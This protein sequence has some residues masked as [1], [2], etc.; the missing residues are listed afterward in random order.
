[1]KRLK[2][3]NPAN[4]TSVLERGEEA[5][6]NEDAYN[7]RI[8]LLVEAALKRHG[9][10]FVAIPTGVDLPKPILNRLDELYGDAARS[11]GQTVA[12]Y[13]SGLPLDEIR[14]VLRREYQSYFRDRTRKVP[15]KEVNF[16]YV[17]PR[18]PNPIFYSP[19]CPGSICTV[20]NVFSA[21]PNPFPAGDKFELVSSL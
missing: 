16:N 10:P 11:S 20:D 8:Q 17:P 15:F 21:P 18:T 1:V 12:Q 2:G 7:R 6:F 14:E 19:Q 5:A 13:F 9:D 4:N 3:G